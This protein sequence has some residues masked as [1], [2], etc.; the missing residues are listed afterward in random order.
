MSQRRSRRNSENSEILSKPAT[1]A[2][3]RSDQGRLS[4]QLDRRVSPSSC[5]TNP[6][7]LPS[8]EYHG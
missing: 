6:D 3:W 2:S 8:E 5:D 4:P 1:I 7:E